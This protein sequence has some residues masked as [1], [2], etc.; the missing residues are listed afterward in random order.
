M[1]ILIVSW[2]TAHVFLCRQV[3]GQQKQETEDT[4]EKVIDFK[5]CT[6]IDVAMYRILITGGKK[7]PMI[8][9]LLPGDNQAG[10][11]RKW[12]QISMQ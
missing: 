5:R 10:G 9:R 6:K 12:V 7:Q 1:Q 2:K 3:K 8:V 4:K 11:Q